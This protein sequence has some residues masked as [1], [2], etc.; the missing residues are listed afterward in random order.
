[1]QHVKETKLEEAYGV[2]RQCEEKRKERKGKRNKAKHEK[3]VGEDRRKKKK[4]KDKHLIRGP[5]NFNAI[6]LGIHVNKVAESTMPTPRI[7]KRK[8]KGGMGERIMV[9]IKK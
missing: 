9:K 8:T 2:S 5:C 1:M 3:Q 4:K 6:S 7:C